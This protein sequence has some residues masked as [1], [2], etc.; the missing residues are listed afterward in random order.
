MHRYD[1]D[2]KISFPSFNDK[3][4]ELFNSNFEIKIEFWPKAILSS[5]FPKSWYAMSFW[6]PPSI[7][8]LLC[9]P[10]QLKLIRMSSVRI[11][12]NSG[13]TEVIFEGF[14]RIDRDMIELHTDAA[15][16]ETFC[17][18]NSGYLVMIPPWHVWD[19][20]SCVRV[21]YEIKLDQISSVGIGCSG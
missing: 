4:Q 10:L 9:I 11:V 18:D 12:I 19:W 17:I 15:K 16:N 21:T 2:E 20:S 1:Q 3:M 14:W 5:I 6:H 7:I 8:Y 13:A